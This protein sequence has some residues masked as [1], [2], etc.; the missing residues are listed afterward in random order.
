MICDDTKSKV[1]NRK[2]DNNVLSYQDGAVQYD[3]RSSF[4]LVDGGINH[5][6]HPTDGFNHNDNIN[7]S[8]YLAY[9][10]HYININYEE[11]LRFSNK[12][13]FNNRDD[14][15]KVVSL[16]LVDVDHCDHINKKISIKVA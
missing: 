11:D 1:N 6:F 2:D 13:T 16:C 8:L 5:L 3:N 15:N 4:Q 9:A 10:D 12:D 7:T 14:N